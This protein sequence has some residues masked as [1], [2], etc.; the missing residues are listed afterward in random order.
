LGY[1]FG[2]F[3]DMAI[4]A[5]EDDLNFHTHDEIPPVNCTSGDTVA[6]MNPAEQWISYA[7]ARARVS[8]G[9]GFR[10]SH[11]PAPHPNLISKPI[12]LHLRIRSCRIFAKSLN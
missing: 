11:H 7:P 9:H 3:P 2:H 1:R 5:I 4:Q 12:H 8:R 10:I 6:I